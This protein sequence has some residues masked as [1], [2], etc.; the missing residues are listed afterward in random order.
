MPASVVVCQEN[1][2]RCP[3]PGC[4]GSGHKNKN[5]SSHRSVSG[6]PVASSRAR[7]ANGGRRAHSART[8][9]TDDESSGLCDED[10]DR[11][12]DDDETSSSISCEPFVHQ[13]NQ[14]NH[15][16]ITRNGNNNT[17]LPKA[18]RLLLQQK[19]NSIIKATNNRLLLGREQSFMD[20]TKNAK[21]KQL[22]QQI[23]N[24]TKLVPVICAEDFYDSTGAN[25]IDFDS[26]DISALDCDSDKKLLSFLKRNNKLKE[27]LS[28][29]ESELERLDI[30]LDKLTAEE[31]E[32]MAKNE[33]LK[34]YLSELQNERN[35]QSTI[36]SVPDVKLE[37]S[38]QPNMIT[39]PPEP[40]TFP[41]KLPLLES[42]VVMEGN[43][44]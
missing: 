29:Y 7:L 38:D 37:E 8:R 36:Q 14:I 26:A 21:S 44:M 22:H 33:S 18:S 35:N 41:D 30:E 10:E 19:L 16:E 32:L 6:C 24:N 39:E 25:L 4:D 11:D 15:H 12:D 40:A 17:S 3:T 2:L 23:L 43:T 5:R 42:D 27:K 31:T 34:M 1:V 20:K 9:F 28:N 13:R